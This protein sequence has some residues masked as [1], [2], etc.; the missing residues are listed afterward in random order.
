MHEFI[1]SDTV[2]SVVCENGGSGRYCRKN[3][4]SGAENV[5]LL[6]DFNDKSS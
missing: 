1:S 6:T 3:L 5:H 2:Q 4:A